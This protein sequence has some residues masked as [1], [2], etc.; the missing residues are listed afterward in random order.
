ML[1]LKNL[2][3]KFGD[4]VAVDDLS[5]EVKSGEFFGFLGPNGAGKTTTIKMI[6]GLIKPTSGKIFICGIDALAEPEKAKS[7]L[8][9][10]P[11]QPFI[12]D[13]LT[14]REFLYFIG[15]LFK[16]KK[17][18]IR[19][20]VDFL[21][22][23]FEIGRWID[24]RV[25]EYSQGMKQRVIIASALLHDPKVIVIDEPMVGLDPRSARI[26][27]DT[28]KQKSKEGVTIF[29]STHSLDVAEEL[30]DTIGII[31]DGKLI[32]QFNA[33]EIEEFKQSRDGKLE[34]LFIELTK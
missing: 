14:G 33:S 31:K 15:G 11:D 13:K 30:C 4:F 32:A 25:E 3:K 27:K 29:M 5:L 16:M 19:E 8:A 21:V 24:K 28:L 7:F 17:E 10:V 9:Y 26:V 2:T 1:Q 18:K 22:D 23:H 34:S 20:K 12:Y 6:A